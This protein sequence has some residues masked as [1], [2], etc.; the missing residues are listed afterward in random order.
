LLKLKNKLN[1]IFLQAMRPLHSKHALVVMDRH[2]ALAMTMFEVSSLRGG[3]MPMWQSTYGSLRF[4]REDGWVGGSLMAGHA[5][6]AMTG[7]NDV[8][9]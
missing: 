3:S 8:C 7:R 6:L 9:L 4:A 5:A 2:A 1:H